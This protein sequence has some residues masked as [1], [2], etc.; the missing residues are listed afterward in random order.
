MVSFV[1][2]VLLGSVEN[3]VFDFQGK[4]LKVSVANYWNDCRAFDVNAVCNSKRMYIKR[5]III[6]IPFIFSGFIILDKF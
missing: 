5:S 4:E 6:K 2:S 1:L 3:S